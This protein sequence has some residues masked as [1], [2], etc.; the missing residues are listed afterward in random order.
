MNDMKV[1]PC[2]CGIADKK[3]YPTGCGIKK[4]HGIPWDRRDKPIPLQ[5]YSAKRTSSLQDLY[6]NEEP[7][8]TF[9]VST[10]KEQT[11]EKAKAKEKEEGRPSLLGQSITVQSVAAPFATAMLIDSHYRWHKKKR[12]ANSSHKD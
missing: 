12:Y 10:K 3:N 7:G 5:P 11:T 2:D 9:S 8:L 6:E 4:E 1:E